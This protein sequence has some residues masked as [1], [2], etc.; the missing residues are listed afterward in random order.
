[1]INDLGQDIDDMDIENIVIS[2]N[3]PYSI[4]SMIINDNVNDN[5]N[6]IYAAY[7]GLE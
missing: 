3:S 6:E 1:M 7:C 5:D 2:P 4:Q